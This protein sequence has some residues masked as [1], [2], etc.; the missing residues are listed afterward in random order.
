MTRVRPSE[1]L[2]FAV[3]ALRPVRT[4]GVAAALL[5]FVTFGATAQTEPP[6][7][8]TETVTSTIPD[9]LPP[10]IPARAPTVPPTPPTSEAPTATLGATTTKALAG[11]PVPTSAPPSVVSLSESLVP[12][13]QSAAGA[14]PLPVGPLLGCRIIASYG[15]PLSSGMGILGR[16]PL[17]VMVKDNADRTAQWAKA[18]P[19]RLHR[20]AF[21]LIAI[22]VQA[23]PGAAGLYRARMPATLID[24]VLGWARTS[25]CLLIL[26][27]QVGWSS[28]PVELAYLEPWLAQNDVHLGLD[29]EWDMPPGVKPGTKI[30]TMSSADVNVAVD[31]LARLVKQNRLAPKLLVVH[32][33]RNFMVTL[34]EQIRTPPE[35]RLVV[36]MD[37][38]GTPARK[39]DSYGVA[40]RGMPT[41][42]TG[43][44]LFTLIDRPMLQPADVLPIHPAPVFINYQ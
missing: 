25:G 4:F 43:F 5:T 7:T 23:S 19:A 22:T 6:P 31:T 38:F 39:L 11:P 36:N 34:P 30:G 40:L 15:N 8:A 10:E 12:V 27:M 20:C 3:V 13:C 28:V 17:D 1:R 44:K 29:P 24:T 18:D 42:L 33:F 32:R 35:I 16:L 2:P 21:E 14:A 37:G 26:D 9:T 41:T